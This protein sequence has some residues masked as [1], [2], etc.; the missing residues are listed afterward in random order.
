MNRFHNDFISL[1]EIF[2]SLS[3]FFNVNGFFFVKTVWETLSAKQ[4]RFLIGNMHLNAGY[5]L[6]PLRA[7]IW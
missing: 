2:H 6:F 7:I 3:F 1:F 5:K 4:A